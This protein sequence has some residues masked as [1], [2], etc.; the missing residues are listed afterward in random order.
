MNSRRSGNPAK[1]AR[2]ATIDEI[3]DAVA[4]GKTAVVRPWPDTEVTIRT[5]NP[6]YAESVVS[7]IEIMD[8][9]NRDLTHIEGMT[10]MMDLFMTAYMWDEKYHP[11]LSRWLARAKQDLNFY[12]ENP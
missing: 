4:A 10:H 5:T 11:A 3:R 6:N 2:Q 7:F 12:K 9:S 1:R 8:P